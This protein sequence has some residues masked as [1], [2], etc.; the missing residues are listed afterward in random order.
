MGIDYTVKVKRREDGVQ[1]AEFFANELKGIEAERLGF[2]SGIQDGG[3]FTVES[4]NSAASALRKD[5]D[6]RYGL[7]RTKEL[8]A[9]L[10][11]PATRREILQE[12]TDQRET[13]S[14][15]LDE[16]ECVSRLAGKIQLAV[17]DEVF[18][19]VE[20]KDGDPDSRMGYM[21]NGK[22]G[23]CLWTSDVECEVEV[24]Y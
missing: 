5:I 18:P 21:R 8:E 13:L 12:A 16:L 17:E 14:Y 3:V 10:A 22:D 1:V 19:A 9:V 24:L 4:L 7:I 11:K 2:G 20:G 6:A 15:F 23:K